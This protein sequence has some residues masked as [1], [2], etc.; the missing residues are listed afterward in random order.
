MSCSP[1]ALCS[2]FFQKTSCVSLR[3]RSISAVVSS[4]ERN[5]RKLAQVPLIDWGSGMSA[6]RPVTKLSIE[7]SLLHVMFLETSEYTAWKIVDAV[8]PNRRAAMLASA[9]SG[10]I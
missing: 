2:L 4:F 6:F 1:T 10:V 9:S 7:M 3:K 8:T 5:S